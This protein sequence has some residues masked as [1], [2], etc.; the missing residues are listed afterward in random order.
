MQEGGGPD[1][2]VWGAQNTNVSK[3]FSGE[4]KNF[5]LEFLTGRGGRF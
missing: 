3:F 2:S 4:G 5:R 1:A